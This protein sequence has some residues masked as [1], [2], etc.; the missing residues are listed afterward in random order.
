MCKC[1]SVFCISRAGETSYIFSYENN[2]DVSKVFRSLVCFRIII[3]C[4]VI[5]MI[6]NSLMQCT[7]WPSQYR[8][9][10]RPSAVNIAGFEYM[11]CVVDQHDP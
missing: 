6:P 11:L 10:Y 1:L 4:H 7:G 3:G 9:K 5:D 8:L 2:T